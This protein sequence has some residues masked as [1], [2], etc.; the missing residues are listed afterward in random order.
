MGALLIAGALLAG[1]AAA[2]ASSDWLVSPPAMP[3]TVVAA[4]VGG[5]QALT[6]SNGL[7]SR[8]WLIVSG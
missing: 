1:T 5:R 6:M 3:V 8:T 4:T 2:A 7:I